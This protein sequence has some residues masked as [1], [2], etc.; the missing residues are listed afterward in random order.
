[1]IKS[2]LSTQAYDIA[3]EA[4]QPSNV[5]DISRGRELVTERLL[6]ESAKISLFLSMVNPPRHNETVAQ[7]VERTKS[8]LFEQFIESG[9]EGD[10]AF[11]LVKNAHAHAYA[12]F[13]KVH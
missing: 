4:G 10:E 12:E 8:F 9:Y 5:I 6:L 1:M 13:V 3:L 11:N 2:L 7:R